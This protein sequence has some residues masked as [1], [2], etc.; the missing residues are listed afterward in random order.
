MSARDIRQEELSNK[1]I[2]RDRFGIVNSAPRTGKTRIAILCMQKLN[3]SSVLI[4]YPD[5]KIKDSWLKDFDKFGYSGPEVTFSTY[6]SLY[7]YKDKEFDLVILD[8]CHTLSSAQIETCRDLF[9]KN[10]QVL[11]LS[12]T[13]SSRTERILREDLNLRVVAYYPIE[14]AIEE[15]ILPDY[16]INIVQTPLDNISKI[17]KK[18][19]TEKQLFRKYEYVANK[20]DDEGKSS[21][22]MKLK[23]ISILQTSISKRLL[24]IHTIKRFSENRILTFCGRTEIADSLGT[25]SYHSKFRD[26]KNW[27]DFVEGRIPH[28][29][30]CRIGGT[31]VTFTPLN[32]AIINYFDSNSENLTQKILRAMSLEYDNPDKKAIIYIISSTEKKE[33]LWL[34][35]ALSM[36]NKDKIKYL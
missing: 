27:D 11:G 19:E 5:N 36:F 3:P 31:G 1:W 15:G 21:F 18:G 20:L 16:E 14:R 24:T 17:G 33:L 13:I 6:L 29:A 26:K 10:K 2:E 4:A 25:P 30:V 34:S 9:E 23:M 28:L 7:K 8:E 22:H 32:M 12:G 35:Q